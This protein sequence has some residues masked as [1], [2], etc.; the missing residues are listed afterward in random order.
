MTPSAFPLGWIVVLL[1]LAFAPLVLDGYAITL[2]TMVLFY[3]FIGQAWNLM[4]GYAGLLSLGHALFFGMGGYVTGVLV[5]KAGLIPWI[6]IPLGAALAAALGAVIAWL[7]FRFSVRGVHFALLTIAF[8]EF[9][10]I[11]VE[12]WDYAGGTGGLFLRNL[13]ADQSQILNLRGSAMIF[14]FGFLTLTAGGYVLCWALVNSRYGYFWRAIREDQDA[15][16]ALGVQVRRMKILVVSIS[17]AM[18]GVA[19]GLFALMNGSLFPDSML[20]MRM[21][22]EII[23]APIIGGL[24]TL[25]GPII[26]AFVVVPVMEIANEIGRETRIFGLGTVVYGLMVFAIIMFL[27]EGIWPSA[28]RLGERLRRWWARGSRHA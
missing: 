11:L 14:Y 10:R 16:R 9:A 18:T 17:A 15:A 26:G 28:T 24:G 8:A 3:A 23:I 13:T 22:I 4:M 1:G 19:G 27:P 25:A 20:G 5:E 12:N 6:G 7:G 21:S 2:L